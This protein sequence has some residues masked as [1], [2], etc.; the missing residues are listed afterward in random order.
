MAASPVEIAS[1]ALL[2]LGAKPIN[3]F[4]EDSDFAGLAGALW[5]S[6][7]DDVFRAH[8]W[9]CNIKRVL[10]S[11]LVSAPV[12]EFGYAFQL[13]SDCLRVLSV[14]DRN[15]TNYRL[16]GRTILMGESSCYLRYVF[17]NE[18]A[19]TYDASLT[20][21]LQYAMASRMAYAVT[22]SSG[23][24]QTMEAQYRDYA[25]SARAVDGLEDVPDSSYDTALIGVRLG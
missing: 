15:F 2:F 7:R 3:S 4:S 14:G 8:P 9:N 20:M 12:Y 21:A 10:L 6:T 19:T 22:K 18:D 25:K 13:P 24:Q 5:P 17:R 1:N 11:P 23:T 16:E